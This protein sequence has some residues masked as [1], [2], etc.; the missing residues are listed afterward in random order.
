MSFLLPSLLG[1][2]LGGLFNHNAAGGATLQSAS[3]ELLAGEESDSVSNLVTQQVMSSRSSKM[4]NITMIADERTRE[5]TMYNEYALSVKDAE[6]KIVT[7]AM[8]L[9]DDASSG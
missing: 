4:S 9:V 6:Q 8:K 7:K 2:L 3:D 1:P 5:V